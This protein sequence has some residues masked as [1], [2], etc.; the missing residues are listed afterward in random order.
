MNWFLYALFASVIF[1]V[2]SVLIRMLLR[3][4]G[5]PQIFTI[6]SNFFVATALLVIAIFTEFFIN[7]TFSDVLV[8]VVT[9]AFFAV[10]STF[11]IYGRQKE[12]VGVVSIVRETSVIWIFIIGLFFFKESLSFPKVAGISLL[13]FGTVL[14]L[15]KKNFFSFSKGEM[16]LFIATICMSV[17]SSMSKVFVEDKLSPAFY[18]MILFYLASFWI[19]LFT[20]NKKLR[21]KQEL[22]RYSWKLPL[23]SSILAVS[24]FLLN[25]GFQTG[26]ISS[27][28]P[29]YT[30]Y[31]IF[32]I[33]AGIIFLGE[34]HNAKRK[35]IGSCIALCGVILLHLFS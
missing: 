20:K 14:A 10:A 17:A 26:D 21:I 32:S 16:L 9:S 3:D 28:F 4:K 30:S 24:I 23:V 2:Y 22:K 13:I 6:I 33:L 34:T 8:M 11:F 15:W 18:N 5:Q 29:V 35:I 19:F 27:V 12:E 31:V 7:I 1:S 25:K